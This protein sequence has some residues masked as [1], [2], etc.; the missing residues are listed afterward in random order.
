MLLR[1]TSGRKL[2]ELRNIVAHYGK[3]RVL[4]DVSIDV[5]ERLT[6]A[7]IGANGA[8][9]STVL[10]VISGLVK[11]TGGSVWLAEN[12]IDGEAV[13]GI[14]RLGIVHVP[15]GRGLF[16][17]MT[18]KENLLVGG[19]KEK[20]VKKIDRAMEHVFRHFPRLKERLN[21]KAKLLSG[22]EQQ[23]LAIGRGL[24]AEPKVLL[25]DE[26]TLGLSPLMGMEIG[27]IVLDINKD[28]VTVVLA[29][30]NARLAF[31]LSQKAYVLE[32]GRVSIEGK[33]EDL[34]HNEEVVR[35]YLSA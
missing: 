8:G 16:G 17:K 1:P 34:T 13:Y 33:T 9:K 31:K 6:V 12:R 7:L 4:S 30:Q 23:M 25:L 15:E 26:P 18:V 29:E 27:Q 28:G 14:A 20:D 10:R 35:A 2:L 3:V 19:Y 32:T 22:G 24:M 21:Q 5:P 11:P